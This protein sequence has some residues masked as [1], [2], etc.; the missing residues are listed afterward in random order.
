MVA[1]LVVEAAG[2]AVPALHLPDSTTTF[3]VVFAILGF[4]ITVILAWAFLRGAPVGEPPRPALSHGTLPMSGSVIAVLP[5]AVR[6]GS[7]FAYL[8]EGMVDLLSS[9]LRW[10][11]LRSVDPIALLSFGAREGGAR[12]DPARAQAIARHFGAGRF[13]V[14]DIL[15]VGGR[16]HIEATLYEGDGAPQVVAQATVEGG[17]TE[18]FELVDD[19]ARQLLAELTGGPSARLTRLAVMTTESLPA[20]KAYLGAESEMRAMRRVPAAEA[21]GRAVDEDPSFAMAWYRLAIAALWSGQ[22]ELS[23]DAVQQGLAHVEKLSK[24]D[25]LLLEA[26][27]AFIAGEVSEA[28]RLYRGIVGIHPDEVEAWYQLGE[29][30]FHYNPRLGKSIV[31][32]RWA[33]ERVLAL[34]PEHV[35][36][37]VH[38]AV[39]AA[40]EGN[41]DEVDEL[42]QR[43]LEISPEGDAVVW[44]Q[45]LR[46]WVLG[47]PI[48]QESVANRVR[49][50]SDFVAAR[51]AWYVAVPS[52]DLEGAGAMAQLLT[53]PSRSQEVRALGHVWLA[54]LEM[55]QGRW[56]AA[57][58]QFAAAEAARSGSGVPY[59][60]LMS[61]A[62]FLDL[63]N[64][65]LAELRDAVAEWPADA[66]PRSTSA[67]AY[68]SAHDGL[69]GQLR[70]YL[71]GLLSARLEDNES[72]LRQ[73]EGLEGISGRPEA[74]ELARDQALSVRAYVAWN[75]GRAARMLKKLEGARL[76][77]L[78]E[79]TISSP[80]FSQAFER[81]QRAQLLEAEGRVDD[82]LCW[83]SS[84]AEQ[85]VF[86]LV[87]L[88]PAHLRS[89][90]LLER[91]GRRQEAAHYYER[92]IE[93]WRECDPEFRPR[94]AA[95]EERLSALSAT[96]AVD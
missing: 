89:A 93:L 37:L 54:H 59:R 25:R 64:N 30:L 71:L 81:F 27:R 46:A 60:A 1:L 52:R 21:F 31:D 82:A 53:E 75:D 84:F 77:G 8:G 32:S 12:L 68:F 56:R 90:E 3:V 92:F 78:F 40:S 41:D 83:Y 28:E 61:L 94:V 42:V 70:S 15:E 87:Y 58:D 48:E 96:A 88:G 63:P 29:V 62:P 33:W 55:A 22:L 44:M 51:C 23:R 16:L 49:R 86:D 2:N 72:A 74:V 47:D 45:A 50:S 57:Q 76:T 20:L 35:S 14:G 9:K 19:L 6:G 10:S 91:L 7:E 24:H 13:V 66:A 18:V 79:L 5:F 73:A 65:E 26:F 95:A 85:S 36:A 4:P 80:F 17:A 69:H 43:A 38:M 11:E 34:E 67:G 39:I